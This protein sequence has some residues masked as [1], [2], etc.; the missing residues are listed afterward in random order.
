[1]IWQEPVRGD[2]PDLSIFGLSGLDQMRSF[3]IRGGP[4]PPIGH[5]TGLIPTRSEHGYSE[6]TM[7]A[8]SWL[9]SPAGVIQ[10]GLLAVLADAP[11]AGAIQTTLPPA[12][13]YATSELSLNFVRPATTDSGLLTGKGRVIHTGRSLALSQAEIFDESERLL[14]HGTTRIFLFPTIDP[15]PA[16]PSELEPWERPAYPTPDPYL[17]EIQ[18]ELVPQEVW[19]RLSGTEILRELING[20]LPAPPI[21]YLTGQHPVQAGDGTASFAMP[22][23]EWLCSPARTVEGGFIAMLADSALSCAVQTTCPPAT[24]Y[25]TVDL[26][27]NFLRPVFP[28]GREFVATAH[29]V[30]RGKTLAVANAEVV[31]ADGKRVMVA[32]STS[33]ILPGRPAWVD[34]PPVPSEEAVAPNSQVGR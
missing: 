33:M 21:Y 12:T 15:A 28:D 3:E 4:I 13:P 19:D 11:L 14:A 10:G 24:A 27:V 17:R 22:C 5:L 23:H 30:H 25:A 6:F 16:P 20:S 9:Q 7:P 26:K 34:R 18:A 8:S 31:N 1:M 2:Y 29:V 32:T